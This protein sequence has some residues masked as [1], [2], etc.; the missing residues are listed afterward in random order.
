M[1]YFRFH[2]SVGNKFFRLNVS[3]TGLSLTS[4]VPGAHLNV[5]LIG[6]RKRKMMATISAPGTGLSYRQ[7]IGGKTGLAP[8]GGIT[9]LPVNQQAIYAIIGFIVILVMTLVYS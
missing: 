5:P 6:Q 7:Q 3:K 8:S 1:G 2:R 9:G 4:G